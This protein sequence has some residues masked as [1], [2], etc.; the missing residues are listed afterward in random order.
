M[1]L[2]YVN[3]KISQFAKGEE[4]VYHSKYITFEGEG[5]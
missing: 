3:K 4:E 5:L 2:R 1:Y